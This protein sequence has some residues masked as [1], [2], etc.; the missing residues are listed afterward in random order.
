MANLR[1]T[2]PHADGITVRRKLRTLFQR[3]RPKAD[4]FRKGVCR[5]CTEDALDI[6][7]QFRCLSASLRRNGRRPIVAI[8]LHHR[9]KSLCPQ[10][11][12]GFAL[13]LRG[14]SIL[15]LQ[16]R[17]QGLGNMKKLL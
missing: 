10:V 12:S 17:Y 6:S 8:Q 16:R 5:E 7:V 1:R 3:Y 14:Q 13:S 11:D 15:M 4:T 9:K 2:M